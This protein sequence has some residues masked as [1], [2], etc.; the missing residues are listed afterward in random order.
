MAV[1]TDDILIFSN[2]QLSI[3]VSQ[4]QMRLLM[5][6][7]G[8]QVYQRHKRSSVWRTVNGKLVRQTDDM[9]GYP[10][11]A[12]ALQAA[13]SRTITKGRNAVRKELAASSGIPKRYFSK[14]RVKA[15]LPTFKQFEGAIRILDF[16]FPL[17]QV[18]EQTVWQR[19]G[20]ALGARQEFQPSPHHPFNLGMPTGARWVKGEPLFVRYGPKRKMTK[21]GY[22]GKMRQPV[23][24]IFGPSPRD[25]LESGNMIVPGVFKMMQADFEKQLIGQLKRFGWNPA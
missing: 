22:I 7:L 16:N 12:I 18:K 9:K 10:L 2:D 14:G 20:I 3:T 11:T 15:M 17:H 25:Y 8:D 21:G 4:E 5:S 6:A 1:K 19:A 23:F 13:L 24:K